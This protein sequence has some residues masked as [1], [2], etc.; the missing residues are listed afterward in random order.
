MKV[1][2]KAYAK[3]NLF[4]DITSLRAD[5][6]HNIISFMQ[7]V[8][9]HDIVT[10]EYLPSDAK[11]I[12]VSCS[13]AEIPTD[14]SNIAYRA[15]E[16]FPISSGNISI[17]IQKNI[18]MSAGLAGGSTDA[19]AVLV[20]LN[21]LIGNKL[22]KDELKRI[23]GTLGADVPFC[24]EGGACIAR[25]I[26]EELVPTVPMRKM[27]LV[28]AK[29]GEGMSTPLA[30]KTLDE[31]YNNFTDYSPKLRMLDILT[32]TESSLLLKEYCEGFYNIFE[33]VV[34]NARPDVTKVKNIMMQSG[35]IRAMMSGSGTS[36]FGV[37]ECEE[38]ARAAVS[39]L[40]KVG[41]DTHLCYPCDNSDQF[42]VQ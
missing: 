27:P 18:P 9:L 38:D 24:I 6:Y 21:R 25:G 26:G 2:V 14:R 11:S 42:A 3:I 31:K 7:S 34:E 8:G 32:K 35:A 16:L 20:A 5:K 28:V 37:F 10:V 19:A 12:S 1:S 22:S 29:L 41:A 15:A 23:G 36:V 4:L 13:V 33:D 39:A 17:H 30:Y 40:N